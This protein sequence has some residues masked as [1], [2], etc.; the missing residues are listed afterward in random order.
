MEAALAALNTW[1]PLGLLICVGFVWIWRVEKALERH[2]DK[3]TDRYSLIFGILRDI[4][5]KVDTLGG[6]VEK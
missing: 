4:Q 6:K 5:S 3:C 2:E 1:G